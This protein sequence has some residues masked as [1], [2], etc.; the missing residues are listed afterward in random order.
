MA[1]RYNIDV[2]RPFFLEGKTDLDK[3]VCIHG[4]A[5][6]L[7]KSCLTNRVLTLTNLPVLA[8][9][10]TQIAAADKNGA[11]TA[12][13]GKGRVLA[14]MNDGAGQAQGVIFTAIPSRRTPGLRN[15]ANSAATGAEAAGLVQRYRSHRQSFPV[16]RQK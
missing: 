5:Q 13:T 3:K 7:G 4:R 11:G 1:P 9:Y 15:S 2:F 16:Y 14:P 8:K 10:T 12:C 6:T